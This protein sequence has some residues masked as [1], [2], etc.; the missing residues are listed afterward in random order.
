M[1]TE[2]LLSADWI[3][4]IFSR[5]TVRYGRAFLAR[6]DVEGIDR[7]LVKADWAKELAGFANWTEAI[8]HALDNLPADDKPPTVNEFKA[9]CFRAPK[10]D[11]PAL[12]APKADPARA[13][14]ELGK[15]D[16]VLKPG[17]RFT[18]WIHRG[19]VD[20][21]AGVKKSPTVERMI[22]QAAAAKGVA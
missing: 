16:R 14:A 2:N 19:L 20:L 13:K 9:A 22:R 17:S 4:Y 10:P 3:E 21:Q 8:D 15:V 5:L 7:N 18:D 6:W 12:P 1:T 11:R